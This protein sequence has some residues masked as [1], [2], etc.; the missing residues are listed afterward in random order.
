MTKSICENVIVPTAVAF[1]AVLVSAL[2]RAEDTGVAF[3]PQALV[4]SNKS[5]CSANC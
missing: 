4:K 1:V 5:N 3:S 2:T